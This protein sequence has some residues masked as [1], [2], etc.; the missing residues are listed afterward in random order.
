MSY[1]RGCGAEI[2]WITTTDGR[3]VSVN[4]DP[5]C[6]IEGEGYRKFITDEGE[7]VAGRIARKEEEIQDLLLAYVPHNRT[8]PHANDFRRGR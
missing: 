1:C 2:E 4:P 6:I 3:N 5:V 8:C 7:I